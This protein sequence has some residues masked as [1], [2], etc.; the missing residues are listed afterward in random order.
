M[1]YTSSE[2]LR[3]TVSTIASILMVVAVYKVWGPKGLKIVLSVYAG[4]ILILFSLMSVAVGTDMK[5]SR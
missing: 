2:A 5:N 1:S 4:S 3:D